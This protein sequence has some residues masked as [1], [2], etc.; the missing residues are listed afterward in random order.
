MYCVIAGEKRFTLLP[1]CDAPFL[2]ERSYPVGQYSCDA[3]GKWS[4]NLQVL[5][6][7]N[8][9]PQLLCHLFVSN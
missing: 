9:P 4:V 5:Q 6:S 2:Y 8:H 3:Q 7:C 1:P